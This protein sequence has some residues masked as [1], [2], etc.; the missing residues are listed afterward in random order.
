MPS[1]IVVEIPDAEQARLVGQLRRAR[2][3]GWLTLHIL[4]LL[5]QQRTPTDIARWLFCSR[6]TV[7][8][9]AA[10]WQAGRRPWEAEGAAAAR[11][12]LTPDRARSLRALLNRAPAALGWTR[13]R[14]SCATL[15]ASLQVRRGWRVSAET[16]RRWL[17]A[18]GWR[19]KRA[20]H[21][22]RNDD[23][24]RAPK[25]ARI[26]FVWQHLLAREALLFADE[27]DV[28]LLPKTGYQ[29]MEQGTQVPV[30]TP[31]R[32]Q[33]AYLAGA[34]DTRT[35]HVLHTTGARKDAALFCA[36][37]DQIEAAYP[38][39]RYD[40]IWLVVDNYRVHQA[41]LVQQ[42]LAAHPRIELLFLPAYCPQANPIERVF[43]DAH[44]KVTRN[45]Q[46]R[47]LRDL[48]ADVERHFTRNGP[49]HYELGS[50]YETPDVAAAYR[51]R[52]RT[53]VQA[54]AA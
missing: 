12:G 46:R 25:L 49:W 21:V 54:A 28:A 18:L 15:A 44:D 47:R 20:K 32:N 53:A 29:W 13:T 5:A 22:A 2:W 37:L 43:G 7:Y 38:A 3:G 8:A 42:W 16:V 26:L 6:T 51:Q 10:L 41:R 36:L 35:G 24:Q 14:W 4:L 19:W 1:R 11:A 9:A 27:L 30:M 33:K 45:H 48:L 23:P 40:R 17:H 50:V 34:W 31:G 39:R 52:E